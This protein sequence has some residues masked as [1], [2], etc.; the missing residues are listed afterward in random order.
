MY[1]SGIDL[2]TPDEIIGEMSVIKLPPLYI[3]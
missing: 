2:S 1:I 3:C